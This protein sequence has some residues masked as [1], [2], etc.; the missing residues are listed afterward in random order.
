[1][2]QF[3]H[4]FSIVGNDTII[5]KCAE[6]VFNLDETG[7]S[8]WEDRLHDYVFHSESEQYSHVTLFAYVSATGD[9]VAHG[10]E[11]SP[12]DEEILTKQD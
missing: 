11:L 6:L 2:S 10:P 1:V 5:A 12:H 3:A 4:S 7:S 8:K 9:A